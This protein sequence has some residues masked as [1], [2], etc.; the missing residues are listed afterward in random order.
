MKILIVTNHC[1]DTLSGGNIASI[2][3]INSLTEFSKECHLIYPKKGPTLNLLNSKIFKTGIVN[4]R[5]IFQKI[6]DIYLGR[7]NTFTNILVPK[8]IEFNPDLIIFDNSRSSFG[9]IN[10]LKS[11]KKN[12]ITIHHNFERE[13]YKSS[14]DNLFIKYPLL[15]Y[16]KKA[17]KLAVLGSDLNITLTFQDIILLQNHYDYNKK[18]L[19]NCIG[20]FNPIKSNFNTLKCSKINQSLTFLI[21]GNLGVN[22]TEISLIPFLLNEFKI[23]LSYFPS[24]KLII[25][26]R[27]P[28]KRLIFLCSK[29]SNI[30]L[31]S[32]PKN[33][34]DI[35]NS[36]D[37]YIC[38]V[39]SGGGIKLRILDGLQ[40]GL[41]ILTHT[42]S[43]RGYEIFQENG[44]IHTYSNL[45]EFKNSLF[46]IF[47]LKQS[48]IN[49]RLE[50]FSL[51]NKTFS[52]ESGSNRL[53]S[54]ISKHFS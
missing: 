21:T 46:K 45:V 9:Y 33:I 31:I 14:Y 38:P 48:N 8:V 4:N 27:N 29:Y 7:I 3:F 37:I 5:N 28:S 43:G 15:F 19:F 25:A 49:H 32:N 1:L 23:I 35:A 44:Y 20:I 26:G 34:S 24:C 6:I 39:N 17:E 12:I 42:I 30:N 36:A 52:F 13:F 40:F 22:Q 53:I 51:Y 47:N 18:A 10:Q 2:A 11:F 41:P 54:L 50:I 16:I